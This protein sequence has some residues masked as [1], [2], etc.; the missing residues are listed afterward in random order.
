VVVNSKT[1]EVQ[2]E[3]SERGAFRTIAPSLEKLIQEMVVPG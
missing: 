3:D 2:L 1:E